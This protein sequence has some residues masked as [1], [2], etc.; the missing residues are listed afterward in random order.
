MHSHNIFMVELFIF[1]LY[2]QISTFTLLIFFRL[3]SIKLIKLLTFQKN[4]DTFK[5]NH[6]I[7][8]NQYRILMTIF[9]NNVTMNSKFDFL[10]KIDSQS[11]N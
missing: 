6:P 3:E 2:V 10:F 8:I 7:L 5:N 11:N 1:T 4:L 9:I